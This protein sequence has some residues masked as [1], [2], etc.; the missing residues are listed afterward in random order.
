MMS[1]ATASLLVIGGCAVD[2]DNRAPSR[3]DAGGQDSPAPQ[4]LPGEAGTDAA[5]DAAGDAA[6]DVPVDLKPD[7]L[8]DVPPPPECEHLCDCESGEECVEGRCVEAGGLVPYCCEDPDC[9]PQTECINRDNTDGLCGEPP[10]ACE[11]LCDCE[12][13]MDCV[14]GRCTGMS[15][16]MFPFC[17]DNPG[18]LEGAPCEHR[19]GS[20]SRCGGVGECVE[21]GQSYQPVVYPGARCCPELVGVE[22]CCFVNQDGVCECPDGCGLVCTRCGDGECGPGEDECNCPGDCGGQ[23]GCLGNHDC[24]GGWFCEKVP[25]D[26]DGRGICMPRPEACIAVLDPVCGCDG[27][28]H[29]NDCERQAAGVSRLHDGPCQ[30]ECIPEGESGPVIPDAPGCCEGLEPV[31]CDQPGPN[32]ECIG[33]DGAFI[34]ARCGN[35]Q[36]GLGENVCNCP[37]DCR[38][39]VGCRSNDD[40]APGQF[41]EKAEADCEGRGLCLPRPE[42]CNMIFDP[43]C[44]C[45]GETYGND[46][47]R[48]AAGVSRLHR[49]ECRQGQVRCGG[50]M[51]L[52]CPDDLFCEYEPGT[53]GFADQMGVCLP[54]PEACDEIWDPVCGCDGMTHSNDCFR[55]M[56]RTFLQH[57]GECEDRPER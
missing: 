30:G 34:C 26:C 38:D 49:G 24:D 3:P 13:G 27:Q 17:C 50:I 46:C 54:V 9:P 56:A 51:G 29:G 53:C 57:D 40:C 55:Q 48:Q 2:A 44:G 41:C 23:P 20:A 36:C 47:A 1:L 39:Q 21:E 18:C 43:V 16:E 32:G 8:P 6:A 31:S 35:G 7:D 52:I 14:E 37:E 15:G 10:P 42:I 4:D 19:D 5:P 12:Q 25:G 33:C 45:D 28:T 22:D 11:H